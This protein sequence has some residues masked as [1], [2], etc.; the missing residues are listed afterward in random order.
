MTLADL[1]HFRTLLLEREENLTEW[2]D[3]SGSVKA[4][5]ARKARSLLGEIKDALGR[6]ENKTFGECKVCKGELE[7]HR[8]EVQP[9]RQ[10]CLACI[11][12]EEQTELE[13][14]LSL[15]SKMHRAL[16][17]Q[18]IASIEGFEVA[19]KSLSAR[20]V[21][22]DYY[23][24]LPA[25]DGGTTRVIIADTMGKGIPAGL[26]MS[27][28]QGALRVLAEEVES[29]RLLLTRLNQWLCRNVPVTKFMS[30]ACISLESGSGGNTQLT[31]SNA[32]HCPPILVRNDG[33]VDRL[34]PTG[35]VLGVHQ[36]FTYEQHDLALSPGDLL[37]LYT[38][39]ITEA[40]N[41]RSEMFGEER[42]IKFVQTYQG[43]SPESFV[44]KLL[45]EVRSFSEKP[46]LSDDS[47]VIALRKVKP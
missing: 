18:A 25:S 35:G 19:V 27:N 10:I 11:S 3:S 45:G 39:G 20:T 24:F 23:D 42:L 34:E 36:A 40:E 2:L 1:E 15:A 28:I 21:G 37:V 4:G 30:L 5:D 22:G 29:P 43:D 46:E 31:Y 44:E 41:A 9:T 13:E 17:P 8:L 16:L 7:L 12:K 26:L 32:G 38:D 14:E 47:T 6:V 33:S